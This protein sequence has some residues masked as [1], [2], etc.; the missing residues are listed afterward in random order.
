M[1]R[2]IFYVHLHYILH[3]LSGIEYTTRRFFGKTFYI[4]RILGLARK[5]KDPTEHIVNNCLC[6]K[7]P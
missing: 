7:I 2:R 5:E 6:K 3:S 1:A 4:D